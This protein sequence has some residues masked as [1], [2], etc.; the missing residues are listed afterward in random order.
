MS[1]LATKNHFVDL[2]D[3]VPPR[4]ASALRTVLSFFNHAQIIEGVSSASRERHNVVQ[5]ILSGIKFLSR[6]ALPVRY[7]PAANVCTRQ[8]SEGC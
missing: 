3:N 4:N 5:F 6:F 7:H 8:P 2:P 1:G